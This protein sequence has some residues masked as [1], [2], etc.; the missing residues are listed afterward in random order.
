MSAVTSISA[1][2]TSLEQGSGHSLPLVSLV[3]SMYNEAAVLETNLYRLCQY[4]RSLAHEYR[5][6]I[7]LINDGRP[8]NTGALPEIFARGRANVRFFHHAQNLGPAQAFQLAFDHSRGDYT[9]TLDIN[10]TY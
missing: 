7:I 6:E 2:K 3:L 8:D 10:L 1:E 9:V 4:M 5:W